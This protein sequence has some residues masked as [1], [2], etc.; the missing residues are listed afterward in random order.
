MATKKSKDEC[1]IQKFID[2]NNWIFAKTYAKTAPHEYLVYDNLNAKMRKEADWF[3]GYIKM[4]GVSRRY[5]RA[6]FTYLYF[7][8]HKY[9]SMAGDN[10]TL[11]INRAIIKEDDKLR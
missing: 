11:I 4:V 10:D 5:F 9:W 3:M 1:R 2:G 8:G 6:L 7:G